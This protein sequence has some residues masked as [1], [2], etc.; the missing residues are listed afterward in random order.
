MTK[1][2]PSVWRARH[3]VFRLN[4]DACLPL[5][6]ELADD[7]TSPDIE[8]LEGSVPSA[9]PDARTQGVRFQV[10]AGR[11]LLSV[12]GVA[13]FL[14]ETGRRITIAREPAA[15]DDDVRA[16]LLGPAF[17]AL[18]HQ[19]GE[20]VL[21]GSAIVLGGEGVLLL[22]ASGA[23]KSTLVTALEKHGGTFLA[24]DLCLV[25]PDADGRMRV[26]AGF[27]QLKL[28]PDALAQLGLSASGLPGVRR[29]VEK[30][31]I[32]RDRGG[33][34]SSV[35]LQK[36]YVLRTHG[37]REIAFTPAAGV[38]KFHLLNQRTYRSDFI[39]GLDEKASH[40][41]LAMQ[42]ARQTPLTIVHRPD[43]LSQ[44]DALATRCLE[45]LRA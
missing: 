23:G 26:H 31:I 28:W 19:R 5:P 27:N 8:I 14:I 37:R 11:V 30:R 29:G 45:D 44:L 16:F 4:V 3:R 40:H 38:H 7:A 43:G 2:P 18:L 12:D 39:D 10:G 15:D 9:L 33:E 6:T 35:L 21:R 41:R 20:L 42:L 36:I 13:R 24:D 34:P 32:R 1:T 25:R 22:G 17:G